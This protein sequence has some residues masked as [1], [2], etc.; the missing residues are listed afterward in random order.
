MFGSGRRRGRRRGRHGR[1]PREVATAAFTKS[2]ALCRFLLQLGLVVVCLTSLCCLAV[3]ET[4]AQGEEEIHG[5]DGSTNHSSTAESGGGD[6]AGGEAESEHEEELE[7]PYAVLYPSLI[8]VL[9]TMIFYMLT[10]FVAFLPYTASMFLLGTFIGL[11]VSWNEYANPRN[12]NHIHQSVVL[13]QGINSEV[14]LLVFLPGL[15]F[16]DSL[17]QNVHLFEIALVQL[18]IF[19]FPCVLAGTVL[20]AL[21]GSYLLPYDWSFNLAMTF[22][23]ILSA[24]DPVAV[25]ALLEEVGKDKREIRYLTALTSKVLMSYT[26]ICSSACSFFAS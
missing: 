6:T 22:G 23:S 19:A 20:T 12:E 26:L 4:I 11:G 24:T 13:W 17:G 21:I 5:D 25:A 7:E 1:Q 9:G 16:K 10:R 2:S 15:I 14:L 18:F 8:L 3:G